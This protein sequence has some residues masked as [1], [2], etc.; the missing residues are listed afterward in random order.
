MPELLPED[1]PIYDPE[2]LKDFKHCVELR[3]CPITITY[4][5]EKSF[6]KDVIKYKFDG[7]DFFTCD[8]PNDISIADYTV[9]LLDYVS[10]L[11]DYDTTEQAEKNLFTFLSNNMVGRLIHKKT[12]E[13]LVGL[14]KTDTLLA[15]DSLKKWVFFSYRVT[16]PGDYTRDYKRPVYYPAANSRFQFLT[17]GD[18]RILNHE[19]K[20]VFAQEIKDLE[21]GHLAL[22]N[23]FFDAI[24]HAKPVL[25][26]SR[27]DQWWTKDTTIISQ[28][29]SQCDTNTKTAPATIKNVLWKQFESKNN[30]MYDVNHCLLELEVSLSN[31]TY[32]CTTGS[33]RGT[34]QFET[35]TWWVDISDFL[36]S[37]DEENITQKDFTR[38]RN[39]MKKRAELLQG[40]QLE[41]L[42][43]P[44][45]LHR[46]SRPFGDYTYDLDIIV[47]IPEIYV[48]AADNFVLPE[49]EYDAWIAQSTRRYPYPKNCPLH[50]AIPVKKL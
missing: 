48:P 9:E 20:W 4:P 10:L 26:F 32:V 21:N 46:Y 5:D 22:G 34:Y 14:F 49:D 7:S 44:T 41:I 36:R 15:P 17:E 40:L 35:S 31:T 18:G 38:L 37:I 1:T 16:K 39:K 28:A 25:S 19:N 47:D 6:R 33:Y 13:V 12:K 43:T 45:D 27:P 24:D 30:P 3:A 42:Y 8:F 29:K 50:S 23:M 11:Y 2:I